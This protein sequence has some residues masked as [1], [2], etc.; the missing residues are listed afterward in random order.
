MPVIMKE[1]S[2]FP[3]DATVPH[4]V[5]LCTDVLL[6]WHTVLE[7]P[8][9]KALA[10][11][12]DKVDGGLVDK[13]LMPFPS[14]LRKC[15]FLTVGK[16][17]LPTL[18]VIWEAAVN[19]SPD[20]LIGV[21][22]GTVCD[23]TG[24]AAATYQRGLS[25][26]LFPTTTLSMVDASLGGKTAID[27]AGIKNSV[28]AVRYPIAT[29]SFLSFLDT[30]PQA[31]FRSGLAESI[32]AAVIR[33]IAFFETLEK[34][35]SDEL[36]TDRQSLLQVVYKSAS[37][38]AAI[39]EDR[40]ANAK[41]ALLYGHAVG[42]AVEVLFQ[43]SQHGDCVAI[44]M[45]IEGAVAYL[46]NLWPENDWR[47]QRDLLTRFGLPSKLPDKIS[48][49]LLLERMALYKK[50]SDSDSFRLILPSRIGAMVQSNDHFGIELNRK[51]I[52]ELL[53]E[54]IAIA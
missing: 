50:L 33:S 30:L 25:H 31:I 32:K 41:L 45:N 22:G 11:C 40:T 16:K 15:L 38:K 43:Q 26:L 8:I 51:Q 18:E 10:V 21:G 12:D 52:E 6:D 39:C 3:A 27:F 49:P 28:G 24:F 37:I 34:C 17:D 20:I 7:I 47:R 5:M 9:C 44:G 14:G 48:V 23:L 54:A 2:Y 53:R 1:L 42:Q 4:R 36:K 19:Y 46:L 13:L 35:D 29:I